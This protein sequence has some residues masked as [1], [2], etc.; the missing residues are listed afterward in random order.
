MLI[1]LI[2]VALGSSGCALL[3]GWLLGKAQARHRLGEQIPV[4]QHRQEIDALRRRYR[5]RL[6]A[7]RDVL[8]RQKTGRNQIRNALRGAENRLAIKAEL[9]GTIELEAKTC[10]LQI[11]ELESKCGA[12]EL[13]I[14]ELRADKEDLQRQLADTHDRFASTEREHGLLRIERDELVART[15]RLKALRAPVPADAE[16]PGTAPVS[17]PADDSRAQIGNLRENLAARDSRIHELAC[18]LREAEARKRELESELHTWKLRIAPLAHHLKRQ[19]ERTRKRSQPVAAA[20][21][22]PDS[23]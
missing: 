9:L 12:Q 10:R 18:Q 7:V 13:V 3:A 2:A 17:V 21:T 1:T 4:E 15:Q 23:V 11:A 20:Q 16:S 8:V 22:E 19:R 14:A 5:R 6:R